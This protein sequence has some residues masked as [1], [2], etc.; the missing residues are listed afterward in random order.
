VILL[1]TYSGK[2]AI[3]IYKKEIQPNATKE[4]LQNIDYIELSQMESHNLV[5]YF[6]YNKEKAA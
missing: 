1:K 5:A 4:E 2:E 6:V 3:K